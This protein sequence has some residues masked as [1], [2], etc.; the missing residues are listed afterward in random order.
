VYV[1]SIRDHRQLPA[2]LERLF[3]AASAASPD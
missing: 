3:A 2:T 1:L